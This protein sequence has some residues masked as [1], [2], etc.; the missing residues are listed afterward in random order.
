VNFPAALHV[1]GALIKGGGWLVPELAANRLEIELEGDCSSCSSPKPLWRQYV[2]SARQRSSV[3]RG[4][5]G[6]DAMT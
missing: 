4:V 5:D 6:I 2:V 1:Q 3:G